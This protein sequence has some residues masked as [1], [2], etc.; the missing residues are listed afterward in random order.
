LEIPREVIRASIS[1]GAGF[2]FSLNMCGAVTGGSLALGTKFGRNEITE[3]ARRPSWSRA[4]RLV[5]HFKNNY[6]TLSCAELTWGFDDFA[7]QSRINRCMGIIDSV[8]REVARLLF[9][10]DETFSDPY[11]DEYFARRERKSDQKE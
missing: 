1:L 2:G 7:S 5:E 9:D 3:G 8:T 4:I 10:P 11:K 6:H